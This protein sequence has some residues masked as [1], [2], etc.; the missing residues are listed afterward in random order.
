MEVLNMVWKPSGGRLNE[1]RNAYKNGN[2][3][4]LI[5]IVKKQAHQI[6]QRFY[7]MEKR[8]RGMS[9]SAYVFAKRETGKE[10]PRYTESERKLRDMG[11][12]D[13]YKMAIDIN[14]K[15]VSPTSTATGLKYLEDKRLSGAVKQLNRYDINIDESQLKEFLDSG[16]AEFLNS[17]YLSSDQLLE[18]Y[19][20][21]VVNGNVT[22]KQF[23]RELKRY[24]EAS[25]IKYNKV[26][27]AWKRINTRKKK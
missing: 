21:Y 8:G 5:Q 25:N 16:G 1:I 12:A 24:R 11:I 7:R 13:L 2:L 17:K 10:K 9:E 3:N 19:E 6:N 18:D 22:M 15:I 23:M 27:A 4:E 20:K 14:V 26:S